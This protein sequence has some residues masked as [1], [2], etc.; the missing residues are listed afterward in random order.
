MKQFLFCILLTISFYDA[1]AQTEVQTAGVENRL[2]STWRTSSPWRIN[3]VDLLPE[4]SGV[5]TIGIEK[6]WWPL[7]LDEYFSRQ[8]V[9]PPKLLR[10][11]S[12]DYAIIMFQL[13]TLGYVC[14]KPIFLYRPNEKAFQREAL[15]LIKELPHAQPCRDKRGKRLN[16]VYTAYIPFIPQHYRQRQ[17]QDSIEREEVKHIFSDPFITSRLDDSP[18]T[19]KQYIE[20]HIDYDSNLLGGENQVKGVYRFTVDSY[21][22]VGNIKVLQSCGVNEYDAEAMRVISSMPRWRPKICLTDKGQFCNET[23]AIPVIFKRSENRDSLTFHEKETHYIDTIG[24]HL[25]TDFS[26]EVKRG[27]KLVQTISYRYDW[28]EDMPNGNVIGGITLNDVNFDGRTDI[29][30][31]LGSYGIQGVEYFDCFVWNDSISKFVH[32]PTFK[33]IENPT[34]AKGCIFSQARESAAVYIYE[35]WTY[36]DGRFTVSAKL[37]QRFSADGTCRYDE[38][39]SNRKRQNIA[40]EDISAFWSDVLRS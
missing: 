21:G 38:Y 33:N 10:K 6:P 5:D 23:W 22:E 7:G 13:D 29:L 16:C 18:T 15:R 9:F 36:S 37:V 8:I 31:S 25:P 3:S 27:E 2:D 40:R 4:D 24:R 26:I 17:R 1:T 14:S 32:T 12:K 34:I 19:A 20:Q 35:R 39:I 11:N 28:T 30:V